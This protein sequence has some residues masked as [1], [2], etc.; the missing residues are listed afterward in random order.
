MVFLFLP[1]FKILG[2]KKKD[3]FE[4]IRFSNI[5]KNFQIFD[6]V[7]RKEDEI[8][9]RM[10]HHIGGKIPVA[11]VYNIIIFGLN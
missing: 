11:M 10:V 4:I 6:Y 8:S 3:V 7:D 5:F 1:K 2:M 9:V